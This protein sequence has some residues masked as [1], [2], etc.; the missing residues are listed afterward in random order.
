MRAKVWKTWQIT[1]T[2]GKNIF[3]LGKNVGFEV[4]SM[5]IGV[6]SQK[7]NGGRET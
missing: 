1:P 6:P 3:L 2:N 7:K 5:M 4:K